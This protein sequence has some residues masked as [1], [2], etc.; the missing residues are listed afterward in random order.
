[1][2]SGD[3]AFAVIKTSSQECSMNRIE[4]QL[5]EEKGLGLGNKMQ[6]IQMKEMKSRNFMKIVNKVI[7]K[8]ADSKYLERIIK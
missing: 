8:V 3:A 5:E 4:S 2:D 6:F 1:M 7:L